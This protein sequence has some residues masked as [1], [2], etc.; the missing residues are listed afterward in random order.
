MSEKPEGREMMSVKPGN[1][2]TSLVV[3]QRPQ[4]SQGMGLCLLGRIRLL[5]KVVQ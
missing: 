3:L 5:K 1:R 4:S 2:V